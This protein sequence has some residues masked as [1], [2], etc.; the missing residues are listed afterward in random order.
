MIRKIRKLL[1]CMFSCCAPLWLAGQT[2]QEQRIAITPIVCDALDIP[3]DARAALNQK[4]LQITVQNGFGATGG[5][6]VLTADVRTSDKRVT[7]TAPAQYVVELEVSIYVVNLQEQLLVAETSFA[8]GS[9]ESSENKAVVRAINRINSRSPIVRKFMAGAR[10]KI[11]DYYA[12][13]IPAIMAKAQS[14]TDRGDYEGALA[15][16]AAVPECLDDYPTVAE[17]MSDVYV[18]MVDKYAAVS[19][20]EAKSKIALRDYKGALD[21]LLYVD[22]SSTRFNEA[23]QM[24][25]AIKNTIDAKERAEM[26]ARMEQMEAQRELALKMHDDEMM[27]RRMQIE[28]S[29]KSA[30]ANASKESVAEQ[31][32]ESLKNWLL[33]KLK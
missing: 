20:Q 4:L 1:V 29:Q 5:P 14:L 9:V 17:R 8:V 12:A 6:F 11:I 15:V 18:R 25:D 7:A 33:G 16:L 24:V 28:A 2:Q 3:A 13:R 22:P 32:Q 26:Q 10:E 19:I 23:S 30:S 27:L 21:A 31:T